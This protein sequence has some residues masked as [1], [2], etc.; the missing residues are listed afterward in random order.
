VL[1]SSMSIFTRDFAMG[2]DAVTESIRNKLGLSFEDAEKAKVEGALNPDVPADQSGGDILAFAEPICL[3][4][5]RSVDYFKSTYGGGDIKQVLLSGGG[6]KIPGI[7]SDL[8][9]R[10]NIDTE[11]INPFRKIG[12]D[13]KVIDAETIQSIGPVA[14]VAVGLALRKIGDK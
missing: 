5:E 1:K 6:A 9:Q 13:K 4:I 7:V 2:G 12:F 10:L 3:E 8:T 11:I 14:A